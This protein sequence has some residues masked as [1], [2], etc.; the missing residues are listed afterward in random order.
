MRLCPVLVLAV[1]I[2]LLPPVGVMADGPL[3]LS[4][5]PRPPQ[6]NGFGIHWS[7]QIYGSPPDAVDYFVDELSAMGVRWVKFLNDGTDGRHNDYLIKRL[8]ERGI[9]PVMRIYFRCNR[10]LDLDSLR[11]LVDYYRP[12]GVFYYELFNEP[13]IP[14]EAGGW[15]DGEQPDPER[16]LNIWLPAARVIQQ[17]G[18]FPA[19]PSLFPPSLKDPNWQESF[20]VRFFRGIKRRGETS[21]LCRSW[22]AVHNYFLN[23]P[24]DYPY[25]EVNLTGRPLTPEEVTAEG[26]SPAEV[27]AINEARAKSRLSRAEGGYYLGSTVEDDPFGFLSFIAYR[28]LFYQIFGFEIPLISTEGGATVGSTEDP[29]YPRVSERLMAEYTLQAFEYM[30]DRA[31]AY[32]F[33]NN[34]WLLAEQALGRYGSP[35]ESWAWYHDRAG[36]HLPVVERLKAHPRRGEARHN[37]AATLSPSMP[38]AT[39]TPQQS[40]ETPVGLDRF[41]RPPQ[42]NGWGI[43]WVPTLHAQPTETVDRFV[44]E[45]ARL[46]IKWVKIMQADQPKVEHEYLIRSLVKRDMMPILRVYR[47]DNTPYEHLEA[48]VRQAVPLGVHYFELYN[49]PNVSGEAGGW[50]AGESISPERLADNWLL[51]AEAVVRAGGL[52]GT[53]ALAPGGNYE[54]TAFLGAFLR[55]IVARG[56]KEILTK[57]WIALHNYFLNHPLDYPEEPVNLQSVPL[58]AQEIAQRGLSEAEVRSIN[59]ARANSRR[60]RSQGGYYRGSTIQ[61]DSNAFRKF[62]AYEA[63]V[64]QEVGF[65]MPIL[66]TEGGAIPGTQEDPRYP[67]VTDDDVARWTVGAFRYMLKEAPAYYFVF[68][69]WLLANLAGG[70]SDYNWENATWF[71]GFA[72]EEM[73]VVEAVR[74]LALTSG[75]RVLG[76]PQPQPERGPAD[77]VR[78]GWFILW[79]DGEPVRCLPTAFSPARAAVGTWQPPTEPGQWGLEIRDASGARVRIF[80]VVGHVAEALPTLCRNEEVRPS[81]SSTPSGYAL[82]WDRRLDGLGITLRRAMPQADSSYW[83]LVS[84]V[85]E[86]E[87]QAGG[88][89]HIFVRLL[90]EGGRDVEGTVVISWQNGSM[91]IVTKRGESADRY[92]RFADFPM[93][94]PLGSYSVRVA[95]NSD[96]VQGLG[97]PSNRHVNYLFIFRR[98]SIR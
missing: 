11:R 85:Y 47:A 39:P 89:H 43:H 59:A 87:T 61:Q 53:P 81:A 26:L 16:L 58:S 31:P 28:N 75:P 22:G 67:R 73:P 56:Q 68:T 7:T 52:P 94:A 17:A 27:A 1:I 64:R 97:L 48:L 36:N 32:Y 4:A 40:T 70:G 98:V 13:E 69:P 60:P 41:P 95:G 76:S 54:D 92:A 5:Y 19:V 66:S 50:R 30:L 42:D 2:S 24:P 15:C 57:S 74:E 29:R 63:I 10:A 38:R 46:G 25:D 34:T 82:D 8:V 78:Q 12:R 44:A 21:I 65:T 23:H 3:P 71:K 55:R 91:N 37:G 96:V 62:E 49:E 90:D 77:V 18:G 84:A 6:D 9:M 45:V 80:G 86:D 33:A 35:W 79:R 93:Y 20:F 14:G 88:R 83:Q 51:A 72:G